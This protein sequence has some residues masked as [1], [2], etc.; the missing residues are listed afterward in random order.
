MQF[1]KLEEGGT[2]ARE[3]RESDDMHGGVSTHIKAGQSS[4]AIQSRPVEGSNV[5]CRDNG[6][7]NAIVDYK[8]EREIPQAGL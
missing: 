1:D 2:I 3:S 6:A 5:Q 8:S 7:V 4:E